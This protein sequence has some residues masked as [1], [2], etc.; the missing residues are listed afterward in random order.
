MAADMTPQ[1]ILNYLGTPAQIFFARCQG[2][3]DEVVVTYFNRL[4]LGIRGAIIALR[5][6]TQL[7]D[8]RYEIE[9]QFWD[10]V[11]L[12]AQKHVFSGR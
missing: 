2:L 6:V 7:P 1:D 8:D 4:G 10:I 12:A 3:S 11:A 9:P 5:L